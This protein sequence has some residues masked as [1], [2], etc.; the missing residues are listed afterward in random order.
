MISHVS[1]LPKKINVFDLMVNPVV[2][3]ALDTINITEVDI[4]SNPQDDVENAKK[5]VESMGWNPNPYPTDNFTEKE[6]T[7][8]MVTRENKVMRAEASSVSIIKFS[9][10]DIVGFVAKKIKKRKKSNQYSS[11]KKKNKKNYP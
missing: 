7:Q 4:F 11:S 2:Q 8:D 9:P 10:S 6:M 5:N 1:Y 3:I